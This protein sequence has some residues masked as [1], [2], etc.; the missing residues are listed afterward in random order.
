MGGGGWGVGGEW[1]ENGSSQKGSLHDE[2]NPRRKL[3]HGEDLS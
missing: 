1:K 3:C 2:Q